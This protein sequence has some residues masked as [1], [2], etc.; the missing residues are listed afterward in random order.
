VCGT[1]GPA[2]GTGQVVHSDGSAQQFT[3]TAPDWA[4]GSASPDIAFTVAY[5]NRPTGKDNRP[6]FVFLAKVPLDPTK[7]VKT[8][9][10]PNVSAPVPVAKVAALHVFAVSIGPGG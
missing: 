3:I 5:R 9:L 4:A 7:T 2:S 6:V 10:L 1:Y 8:V